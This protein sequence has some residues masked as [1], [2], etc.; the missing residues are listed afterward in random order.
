MIILNV[1]GLNI[2]NEKQNC[3]DWTKIKSKTQLYM[4]TVRNLH[5]KIR[6]QMG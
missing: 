3:S 6:T 5:L 4:I 1:N 2:P